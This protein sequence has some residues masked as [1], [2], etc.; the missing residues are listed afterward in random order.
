MATIPFPRQATTAK[1][2]PPPRHLERPERDL[3]RQVV[4]QRDF[5]ED[6]ARAALA[7]ALDALARARR[8]REQINRDGE[9]IRNRLGEL[10]PHPLLN[11]EVA[12]MAA[13]TRAM[14]HLGVLT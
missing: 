8:I 5:S 11:S 6:A 3:W 14:K 13:F 12:A 9:A 10:K 4:R 2:P 7:V 1:L